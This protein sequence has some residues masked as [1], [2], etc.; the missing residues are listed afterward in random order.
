MS[1][2]HVI[3]SK[4]STRI[5]LSTTNSKT[6]NRR[7]VLLKT[8]VQGN[9]DNVN[10]KPYLTQRGSLTFAAMIYFLRSIKS[11][12]LLFP[13]SQRHFSGSSIYFRFGLFRHSTVSKGRTRSRSA[14]AFRRAAFKG[15][16]PAETLTEVG[17]RQ[18]RRMDEKIQTS[19]ASPNFRVVDHRSTGYR[20]P[21]DHGWWRLGA[22]GGATRLCHVLHAFK[23]TKVIYIATWFTLRLC[24]Y[25][26]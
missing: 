13:Y 17:G 8:I 1:F 24:K 20:R 10:L 3:S 7:T 6:I 2:L 21:L 11:P 18:S 22:G 19:A 15:Q 23:R 5:T 16:T 9:C 25:C 14:E 26:I 4:I 12:P